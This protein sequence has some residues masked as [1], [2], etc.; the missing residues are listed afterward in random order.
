MKTPDQENAANRLSLLVMEAICAAGIPLII[1]W[2]M[3]PTN[4]LN[5]SPLWKLLEGIGSAC[6]AFIL[7]AGIPVG[8]AGIRAAK[9]AENPKASAFVLPVL[10]LIAGM[11]EVGALS[12]IFC[13][14][15]FGGV[16][17]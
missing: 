5:S 17:H 1:W 8:I 2:C 11:I 4:V 10:S 3:T 9:K 6:T 12:L 15:V 13:A 14:V 16:T 7:F